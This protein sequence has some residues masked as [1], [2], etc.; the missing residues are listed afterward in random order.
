MH[1]SPRGSSVPGIL[2]AIKL[3]WVA[4]SFSRDLPDPGIGPG[5]PALQ[6]DSLPTEPPGKPPGKHK[7][8]KTLKVKSRRQMSRDLG[9]QGMV[10]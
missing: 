4:I 10:Q 1:C 5:S 3:V 8:K 2:Q 7:H 6:V 9:T